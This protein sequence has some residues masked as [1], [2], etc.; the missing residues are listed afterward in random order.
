MVELVLA[1]GLAALL[2]GALLVLLDS[3][4]DVFRRTESRR[5][6]AEMGAGVGELLDRDLAALCGDARGDLVAQWLRYD[7]DGDGIA[8]AP[9]LRLALVRHATRA[10]LAAARGRDATGFPDRGLLEVVWT[11]RPARSGGGVAADD[12]PELL[13]LRGERLVGDPGRPSLLSP[14]AWDASG[15]TG[16]GVLREVTAGVLWFGVELARTGTDLAPGWAVGTGRGDAAASWD[17]R[18]ASRPDGELAAWNVDG[19]AMEPARA[20]IRLP[21]RVRVTLELERAA[22]RR[23][24]PR[25]GAALQPEETTLELDDPTRAP[26]PGTAILVGEEWM[27]VRSVSGRTLA[28]ERGARDTGPAPHAAGALVHFGARAVR[29][30]PIEVAVRRL[31]EEGPGR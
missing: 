14:E 7:T 10:E 29:E 4:L 24:R 1:V 2:S 25:L 9:A 20:G 12:R 6:L 21:R 22:D 18:G 16:A 31:A 15:R 5:D 27:R 26:A 13:L 3:S 17:A 19:A 11:A 8:R 23:R 30:V 28:V